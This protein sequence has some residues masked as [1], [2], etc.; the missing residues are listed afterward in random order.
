MGKHKA[1]GG[2]KANQK[3]KKKYIIVQKVVA[4]IEGRGLLG[5]TSG[6]LPLRPGWEKWWG[7]RF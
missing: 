1:E 6:S 3:K 5:L 2:G 7:E 4:R